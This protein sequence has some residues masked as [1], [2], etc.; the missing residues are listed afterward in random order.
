MTKPIPEG[1]H[2]VTPHLVLSDASKAIEFYK[3]AFGAQEMSRLPAQ[4]GKR[5]M[6]ACIQIGDSR[7]FLA[8]DFPEYCG[9]MP[10]TPEALK[11]SPV[12]IHLYVEDIDAVFK[13]AL[14]AGAT[15]LMPPQDMFWGDRYGRLMDPFYHQWSLATRI[16]DMQPAEMAEAAACAFS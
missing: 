1:A 15:E 6:H 11:G 8:D 16:K 10:R 7:V 3:K 12:T 5:L 13:Q 14:D 2:T 9:G 4:D